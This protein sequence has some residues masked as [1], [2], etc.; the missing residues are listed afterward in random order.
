MGSAGPAVRG[1]FGMLL[2]VI[3]GLLC[4]P[5][6]ASCAD[7]NVQG[8]RAV[9]IGI[10]Y[11]RVAYG[12]N[13]SNVHIV[14]DENGHRSIPACVAFT[15]NG[16]LVG[17]A[18]QRWSIEHPDTTICNPR[19]LLGRQWSDP[20]VQAFIKDLPYEVSSSKEGKPV[21]KIGLGGEIRTVTPEK[22]TSLLIRELKLM[23]EASMGGNRTVT[24]AL[25]AVPKYFT[26][27]Q[28]D[29]MKEAGRL[30]GVEVLRTPNE[31]VAISVA[32]E[33]QQFPDER[34][35][36]VVDMGNTLDVSVLRFEDGYYEILATSRHDGVGA[37][38]L[39]QHLTSFLAEEWKVRTGSD[40][41]AKAS[42]MREL[43]LETTKAITALSADGLDAMDLI[44]AGDDFV[45]T[46]LKHKFDEIVE[47][48]STEI[49]NS[50]RRNLREAELDF[51]TSDEVILAGSLGQIPK[52]G[53]QC[54]D[55]ESARTR[56]EGVVIG[57]A[58]IGALMFFDDDSMCT[59]YIPEFSPFDLGIE[60]IDGYMAVIT[61]QCVLPCSNIINI[62]TALDNQ[63]TMLIRVLQGQRVLAGHNKVIGEF[64][65]PVELAPASFV[66]VE[67]LFQVVS[68]CLE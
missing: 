5:L 43:T 21:F 12:R 35:I 25:I 7:D 17:H 41:A 42:K 13:L 14:P 34:T 58:R 57:A 52:V 53:D 4:C 48:F 40:P 46:L 47:E 10:G 59:P 2:L 65:I 54:R 36:I 56:G 20:E 26:D 38:A 60:T 63:S 45:R 51:T 6:A 67:V 8:D 3:F 55:L 30:A 9:P 16:T 23:A 31:P 44:S 1:E 19:A 62:T 29:G 24:E 32:Y 50:I 15:E 49:V 61:P 37:K 66:R 28:R 68:P 18:A 11:A 27:E 39:N 22:V 33:E 64:E